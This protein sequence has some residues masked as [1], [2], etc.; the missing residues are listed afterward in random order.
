MFY[1]LDRYTTVDMSHET[2]YDF[3]A[4]RGRGFAE[5]RN[6]C[7]AHVLGVLAGQGVLPA[8]HCLA[9][10]DARACAKRD[11]DGVTKLLT[12]RVSC[13]CAGCA[14]ANYNVRVFDV[15]GDSSKWRFQVLRSVVRTP[16]AG[17]FAEALLVKRCGVLSTVKNME[18]ALLDYKH[19]AHDEMAYVI[20]GRAYLNSKPAPAVTCTREGDLGV[21]TRTATYDGPGALPDRRTIQA[22]EYRITQSASGGSSCSVD[23]KVVILRLLAEGKPGKAVAAAAH[24]GA[25][26][27]A[28]AAAAASSATDASGVEFGGGSG[29]GGS[30]SE[31]AAVSDGDI[32]G[33]G[34]AANSTTPSSSEAAGPVE[35]AAAAAALCD[36]G[37]GRRSGSGSEVAEDAAAAAAEVTAAGSGAAGASTAAFDDRSALTGAR[38][39]GVVSVNAEVPDIPP[40]LSVRVVSRLLGMRYP[41]DSISRHL[42]EYPSEMKRD[43]GTVEAWA[44]QQLLNEFR[45]TPR[46]AVRARASQ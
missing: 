3:Q 38:L 39:D 27:F 26:A 41:L 33:G 10:L 6:A 20:R 12:M 32:D 4:A 40:G 18:G 46:G 5:D 21:V 31:A 37:S 17:E 13:T 43:D 11:H 16:H 15:P 14:S 44:V 19:G 7:V 9:P 28:A 36:G 25:P 45:N 35:A 2:L 29:G 1:V 23:D 42:Q 22:T 30:G 24:D 34:G 8:P